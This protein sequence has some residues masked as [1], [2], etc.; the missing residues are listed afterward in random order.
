MGRIII[1]SV[2]T[3]YLELNISDR[4]K[5]EIMYKLWLQTGQNNASCKKTLINDVTLFCLVCY[6]NLCIISV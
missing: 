3:D 5:T 2:V 6:R 1:H 4:L